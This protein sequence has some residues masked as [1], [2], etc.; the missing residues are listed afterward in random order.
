VA[1]AGGGGAGALTITG[2]AST[3]PILRITICWRRRSR[4]VG[5]P[6]FI[7]RG[8]AIAAASNAPSESVNCDAGFLKYVRAAASAP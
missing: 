6:G 2:G 7:T 4:A 5:F 3:A 1:A 8:L